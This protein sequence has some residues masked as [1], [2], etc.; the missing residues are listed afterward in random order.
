MRII[1]LDD[2]SRSSRRSRFFFPVLFTY[3]SLELNKAA[4]YLFTD[5]RVLKFSS[6]IGKEIL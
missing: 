3:S 1:Y 4:R 6:F 2:I 5:V